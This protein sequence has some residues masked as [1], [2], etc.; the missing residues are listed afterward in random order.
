MGGAGGTWVA[1]GSRGAPSASRGSDAITLLRFRVV[2]RDYTPVSDTLRA[3]LTDAL[4]APPSEGA[5]CGARAAA[6]GGGSAS[7][8][9][10]AG[11][12][13]LAAE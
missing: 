1:S 9:A 3:A 4:L 12:A 11:W 2:D 6:P 7:P 13:R 5:G 8:A 10:D